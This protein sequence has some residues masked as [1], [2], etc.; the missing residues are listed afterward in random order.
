VA[1][2]QGGATLNLYVLFAEPADG[3]EN[4]TSQEEGRLELDDAS[5]FWNAVENMPGVL[6]S[7]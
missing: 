1:Y 6:K 3:C 5:C 7:E 4:S 2:D